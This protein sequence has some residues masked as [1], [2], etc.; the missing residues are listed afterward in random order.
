M[1]KLS[2]TLENSVTKVGGAETWKF[3]VIELFGD[4][5]SRSLAST[6]NCIRRIRC[7]GREVDIGDAWHKAACMAALL[8]PR[9]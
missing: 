7:E 6:A 2:G 1:F 9:A 4:F 8:S 5:R 3:G